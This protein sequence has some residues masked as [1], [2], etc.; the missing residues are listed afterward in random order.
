M[1]ASRRR[2]RRF[3]LPPPRAEWLVGLTAFL[4][5]LFVGWLSVKVVSLSDDLKASNRARDALAAQVQSL[6][7]TPV[8]GPPGSRGEAGES[9][10]GPPGPPGP[11]GPPGLPGD[12]GTGEPG[13]DGQNGAP[14]PSGAPGEPGQ[15][16]AS[17]TGPAGPPGPQGEPGPAGPKG[18]R[19]TDGQTC[20]D[21]YTL[22]PPPGDPDALVCRKNGPS[23]AP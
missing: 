7:Q 10:I 14:G 9:I 11:T 21:G 13:E 17:V 22:Q 23:D 18:E 12:D 8:A 15:D 5:L 1:S 3:P 2:P 6:G 4:L 16:G 20:P 19:G